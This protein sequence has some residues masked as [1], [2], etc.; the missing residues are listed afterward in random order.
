[1]EHAFLAYLLKKYTPRG[2]DFWANYRKTPRNEPSG[3]VFADLG[4]EEAGE[5]AGVTELVF[6]KDRAIHDDGIIRIVEI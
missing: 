4:M 1:M 3:Q 6:R 2:H 5:R